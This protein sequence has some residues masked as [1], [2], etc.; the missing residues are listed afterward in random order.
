M[1]L[2]KIEKEVFSRKGI[3]GNSKFFNNLVHELEYS[4]LLSENFPDEIFNF[5]MKVLSDEDLLKTKG[6]EWFAYHLYSDF[7]KMNEE[8]I[9]L[10]KE[11]LIRN[12]KNKITDELRYVILDTFLRKFKYQD[13]KDM[14]KMAYLYGYNANDNDIVYAVHEMIQ[15]Y[16]LGLMQDIN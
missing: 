6:V 2:K 7:E 8:Q 1:E 4:I 5:Y 3:N 9:I 11:N 10:F 15:R 12:S 13:M 16:K 14:K